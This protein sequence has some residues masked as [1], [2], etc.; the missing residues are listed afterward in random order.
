MDRASPGTRFRSTPSALALAAALLLFWA[1]GPHTHL[2]EILRGGESTGFVAAPLGAP[3]AAPH[4]A[5]PCGVCTV[6]GKGRAVPLPVASS[7][8]IPPHE[9]SLQ[10]HPLE[11]RAPIGPDLAIPRSR[12]PPRTA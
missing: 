4:A 6:H 3:D 10:R 5:A 7:G 11:V 1:S 12:A 2:S 8:Y 9:G